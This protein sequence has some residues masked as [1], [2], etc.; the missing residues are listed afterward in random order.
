MRVLLTVSLFAF[1]AGCAQGRKLPNT[2]T[3]SKEP[4]KF[5]QI[6]LSDLFEGKS[7]KGQILIYDESSNQYT[8][9]DYVMA[10]NK[11]SPASTFKIPNTI[12]G[13]ETGVIDEKYIFTYGPE[14]ERANDKWNKDLAVREAFQVSCVPCYQELA[15]KIGVERM[16]AGLDS[17]AYPGMEVSNQNLDLFWLTGESSISA[18]EQVDFLR[19]MMTKQF[20]L[21]ETT[22]AAMQRIMAVDTTVNGIRYAK[23]GWGEY[24]GKDLGWYIGYIQKPKNRI[25]FA[26]LIIR[27]EGFPEAL[28]ADE[29]K[30]LTEEVLGI[31]KFW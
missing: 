31:L 3:R 18:L 27:E 25:Y 21:Q 10:K 26:T 29:R 1:L 8:S 12:I 28:F 4:V 22:R 23:T 17:M 24:E 9:S 7:L 30:R 15:R 14:E 5:Q 20:N 16:K 6:D 19:R 13:L 11:Y 2:Y